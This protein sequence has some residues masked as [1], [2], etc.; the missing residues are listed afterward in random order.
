MAQKLDPRET[1]TIQ[2]LAYS[3]MMEQ[4]ALVRLLTKKGIISKR[5][6]LDE[7]DQVAGEMEVHQSEELL[8]QK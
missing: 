8:T 2:E 6:F 3:N 1:V 4:E 7:L 5:E